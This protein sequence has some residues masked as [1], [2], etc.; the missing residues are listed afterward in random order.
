MG[1][2][3]AAFTSNTNNFSNVSFEVTDGKVTISK[4]NITFTGQSATGDGALAYNGSKQQITG[5]T[6]Q[7]ATGDEGLIDGHTFANPNSGLTYKAE[8]T[9]VNDGEV[10]GIFTGN[11]YITDSANND[12]SASYNPIYVTGKIQ[13]K[14]KGAT[15][16]KITANS[17]TKKYDGTALTLDNSAFTYTD[18]VLCAGDS[19]T[20]TIAGSATN[21]EDSPAASSVSSYKILKGQ[22]DVTNCYAPAVLVNGSL[23]IT[24]RS[25]TLTSSSSATRYT[26]NPYSVQNV[27]VSGDGF[28]DGQGAT[29]SNFASITNVSETKDNNNTFSYELT[30]ATKAGNYEITQVYGKLTINKADLT[31]SHFDYSNAGGSSIKYD[32]QTHEA[33]ITLKSQYTGA[34]SITIGYAKDSA[35]FSGTPKD[36]GSYN[37]YITVTAGDNFNATSS[38]LTDVANWAFTITKRTLSLSSGSA[39]KVYDGTP[40]TNSEITVAETD[41][42]ATGEGA[43]YDIKGTQTNAGTSSN[44]FEAIPQSGTNFSNYDISYT[45]GTLTVTAIT[46][47]VTV[48]V[49]GKTSTATYDA[50]PHEVSGYYL[51]ADNGLY[52]TL[53]NVK[54]SGNSTVNKTDVSIVDGQVVAYNMGL[55]DSDFANINNNFT[56]VE[57]VVTDGWLRINQRTLTISGTAASK[58]YNATEQSTTEFTTD[59]LVVSTDPAI[60]HS[61]VAD[62]VT[63]KQSGTTVGHYTGEFSGTPK[64]VDTNNVDVTSNYKIATKASQLS[65][66]AISTPITITADSATK[67]YDATSLTK[68]TYTYTD[69]VL[70]SGD[71]LSAITSGT[72]YNAGTQP[73][74]IIDYAVTNQKGDDVT[75]CYTFSASADGTLTVTKRDVVLTSASG[76][77]TYDGSALSAG[78]VSVSGSGFATGQGASYEVTGTQT[79]AG[80]SENVFT[81]TLNAGTELTNYDITTK[82][83]TLLVTKANPT[84]SMFNFTLSRENLMYDATA[85]SATVEFAGKNNTDGMGTFTM[86][87]YKKGSTTPMSSAPV[88][89]GNYEVHLNIADGTNYNA[90]A[91]LNGAS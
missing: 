28:V 40:L 70:M 54:F 62:S 5:I 61:L 65:I 10:V 33:S 58:T 46:S 55:K 6:V 21:V 51:S 88:E 78:T 57:F 8:A 15:E 48:T 76:R 14:A 7:T 9:Y 32:G 82:N 31:T 83:G 43:T 36:V 18:G 73:N 42:F 44:A 72:I 52:D 89:A 66:T 68:N 35:T 19:I 85:V 3:V 11:P 27:T 63:Y 24:K 45:Y 26:G 38:A 67:M 20:A 75:D 56:T 29:Y 25:V 59:G 53:T 16:F 64:V 81:Y 4:R 86:S 47:K 30:D 39:E 12:V 50:Q 22:V 49:T 37:A 13:I 34:G 80:S 1:L 41:G 77:K 60:T 90:N 79:A 87:Y 84:V 17:A 74:K 2:S 71:T 91:D 23:T 69:G